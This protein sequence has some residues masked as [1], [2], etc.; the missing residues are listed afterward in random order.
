VT[1]SNVTY[2]GKGA[3]IGKFNGSQSNIGVSEGIILS[4][5]TVLDGVNEKGFKKGPVG[6]NN[7]SGATTNW[8]GVSADHGDPDLDNLIT[9]NTFDAAVLE[10]DFIPQGDTVEFQYIFASEEYPEFVFSFN[11][12]F[13]FFISGP[14]ISGG[15][16]NLALVPGTSEPVS[17]N[18]INSST[19]TS[20]YIS[21]GNGQSGS[22]FTDPKA[23]QFDGFT[24][25][26]T[27]ISKV[28]PCKK[29]HLK[30]AIADVAD[31]SYDS[32]VFLKG[33]S[34]SSSPRF[35]PNQ[36]SSVDVGVENLLPEGCSNGIL[37]LS[38][39]DKL[40]T[41]YNLNYTIY[42]TAQNGIDYNTLSGNVSFP[43]N[44]SS[45]NL[46]I[47]PIPDGITES[48]ETVTLRFPNPYVCESDSVDYTYTISDLS[49]MSSSPDSVESACPG[50]KITID[51]NFK[52]GYSPYTYLWSNGDKDVSTL[53]SPT[54]TTVYGFSVSDVCGSKTSNILRVKVPELL[55]LSLIMLPKDTA[56]ICLGVNVNLNS[57]VL[58]GASPYRYSWSTGEKVKSISPQILK[59][60]VYNLKITDA[61]GNIQNGSSSVQLDYP[62]LKVEINKD[63]V[64]CPGDS[65]M[66]I[67]YV[68][69]GYSPY[70]FMWENG[71]VTQRS[72]FSS[73][74]S[75]TVNLSV[76]DSCGIIPSVD[77]A[78]LTIQKPI[79]SFVINSPLLETNSPIYFIDN[80]EGFVEDYDWDFGNGE[81]SNIYNPTTVYEHDS[82]YSVQ[83]TV[84]DS[85]GC[86]DSIKNDLKLTTSIYL[87]VP[88]A[89]S[90]N[91]YK[92][93][94][95]SEFL[96]KGTG[97]EEFKISI[98]NRWGTVIFSSFDINEGW[99][100]TFI[101]GK[102]APSGVYIYKIS[103]TGVSGK[104]VDRVGSVTLY[105]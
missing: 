23:V 27:A 92:D 69:G 8:N 39:T 98:Y 33:G 17:I 95:N 58:G 57:S 99:D 29:Y 36:N 76:T 80:S 37:E 45:T 91:V 85:K 5:G 44:V 22:S 102:S 96:A 43:P 47:I 67:A 52:G 6:P 13:A 15:I 1:V 30:I 48:N 10:F 87:W 51:A 19:N 79:A 38:R 88:N 25:P 63:T 7:N 42:G 77:S 97:I 2:R 4:T 71:D 104:T 54:S 84:T 100:G 78:Q 86:I 62:E 31:G 105:R 101:S 72:R 89:F 81:F 82:T 40:W 3:A 64:V 74:S 12:V 65:V 55:P 41:T 94:I 75:R 103:V 93:N 53:V 73:L 56:V 66:F 68:Q 46:N 28:T 20:L 49:I 21:N 60:K 9:G 14:G 16:Q 11:D 18:T 24:V 70:L 83:L 61:C 34:L 26:L 50:D 90:P 32:G 35:I 59:T